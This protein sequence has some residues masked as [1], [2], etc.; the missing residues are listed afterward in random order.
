MTFTE[1]YTPFSPEQAMDTHLRIENVENGDYLVQ[2]M[3]LNRRHGSAFDIW[4]SMGGLE[5][6]SQEE[7]DYLKARSTPARRKFTVEAHHHTLEL[8]AWLDMLEVRLLL[9]H[10][11]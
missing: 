8:D 3:I 11:K 9:I 5:M 2:E 10:K 6:E 4:L 1:R 7:S